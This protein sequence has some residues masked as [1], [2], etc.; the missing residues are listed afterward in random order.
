MTYRNQSTCFLFW[1][2]LR[3]LREVGFIL[4]NRILSATGSDSNVGDHFA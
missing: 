4:C 1:A 2:L 3:M